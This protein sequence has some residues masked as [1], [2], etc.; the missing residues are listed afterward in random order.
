MFVDNLFAHPEAKAGADRTLGGEEWLEDM[1][2]ST[3]VDAFAVV[4]YGYPDAAMAVVKGRASRHP[5]LD[6]AFLVEG[7][8]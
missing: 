2:P 1:L 5:Q 3:G 6:N 4:G 7:R 8:N